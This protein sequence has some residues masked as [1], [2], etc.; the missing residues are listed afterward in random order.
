MG[1]VA[2][3]TNIYT[4]QCGI[5]YY[6]CIGSTLPGQYYGGCEVQYPYNNY[7]YQNCVKSCSDAFA[8]CRNGNWNSPYPGK[9]GWGL[10]LTTLDVSPGNPINISAGIYDSNFSNWV[11]AS[12]V[13]A[14]KFYIVRVDDFSNAGSLAAVNWDLIANLGPITGTQ[15]WTYTYN[16][17]LTYTPSPK[18]YVLAVD[19]E[20]P[21]AVG[22]H[23]VLFG[24][25]GTSLNLTGACAPAICPTLPQWGLIIFVFLLLTVSIVSIRK[26]QMALVYSDS[27]YSPFKQYIFDRRL[28][29]KVL[30]VT[31]FLTSIICFLAKLDNLDSIGTFLSAG[32]VA[33]FL[34]LWIISRNEK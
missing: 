4:D 32:F 22:G 9:P 19:F 21:D 3:S 33:Y 34:H 5:S 24:R 26:K 1:H 12:N 2:S 11:T 7:L 20:S 6:Y 31:L 28:Y 14:V 13:T 29:F 30:G 17:P 10:E 8:A 27:N 23:Y 16:V 25:S 15:L 18:G